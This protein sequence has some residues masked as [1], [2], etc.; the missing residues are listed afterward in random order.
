[1]THATGRP[2]VAGFVEAGIRGRHALP[3]STFDVSTV[4]SDEDDKCEHD[5]GRH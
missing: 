4:P 1:M 3:V 5:D 2:V